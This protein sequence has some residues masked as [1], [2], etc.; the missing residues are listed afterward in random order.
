MKW[1]F[2]FML[3]CLLALSSFHVNAANESKKNIYLRSGAKIASGI[4]LTW[5]GV[6]FFVISAGARQAQII[7]ENSLNTYQDQ[8]ANALKNVIAKISIKSEIQGASEAKRRFFIG[9]L[10]LSIPGL[11]LIGSGVNEIYQSYISLR[12]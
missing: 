11:S 12:N 7:A 2:N 4:L 8:N 5:L 6:G 9:G 10:V 3:T 1:M